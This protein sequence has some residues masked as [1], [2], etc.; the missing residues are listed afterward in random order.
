MTYYDSEGNLR[1]GNFNSVEYW[2]RKE[3]PCP[4]AE[5]NRCF[6]TSK[7]GK[8]NCGGCRWYEENSDE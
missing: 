5:G 1:T 7:P 2:R 4:Y 6:L 8:E 3:I